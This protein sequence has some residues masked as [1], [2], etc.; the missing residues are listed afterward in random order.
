VSSWASIRRRW[1]QLSISAA[2]Q[3]DHLLH[4]V[5]IIIIIIIIIISVRF[6]KKAVA[7]R[8]ESVGGVFGEGTAC[9]LIFD[10]CIR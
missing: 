1:A 10:V 2:S 3:H 8:A 5:I 4:H 6:V 7:R 9:L